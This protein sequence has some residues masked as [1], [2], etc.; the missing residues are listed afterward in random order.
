MTEKIKCP[1]CGKEI[2]MQKDKKSKK[3]S[4]R[5]YQALKYEFREDWFTLN[6]CFKGG[7]DFGE[8][9]IENFSEEMVFGYL[10]T[11]YANSC[12]T[13]ISIL[14]NYNTTEDLIVKRNIASHFLPAMFCFRQYVELKL[15]EL[16]VNIKKELPNFNHD[17]ESL[18]NAIENEL[19]FNII[20]FNEAL[21]FIKAKEKKSQTFFRYLSKNASEFVDKIEFC[22]A[23][24]GVVRKII[25]E[26]NKCVPQIKNRKL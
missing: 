15:K 12:L 18:K 14:E 2:V 24:F 3:L 8:E 1:F 25:E 10:A 22:V 5:G 13:L 23:E 6:L 4:A 11:S 9:D 20:A 17:I 16:Y 21:D 26:I 7:M 19:D